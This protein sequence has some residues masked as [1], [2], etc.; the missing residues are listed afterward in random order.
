MTNS[1]FQTEI[2][3]API[4]WNKLRAPWEELLAKQSSTINDLDVTAGQ[5]WAEILW[6]THLSSGAIEVLTLQQHA[7]IE[8]ILP[9]FRQSK[10]IR[11]LPFRGLA[12]ITE[13]YSGRC[14][15][16]LREQTESL[17]REL[18]EK[19]QT[20]TSAWDLL[21][22]TL[23]RDSPSEK[24]LLQAASAAGF[25][26]QHIEEQ[27]SPYIPFQ[28][29]WEQHFSSLPKK[30]R[31]TIRNGEK[32]L[33]DR[34]E[35]S[36]RECLTPDDA[37]D[38]NAAVVEIERDSWKEAAGTSIAANPVHEAFHRA[39]TVRAAE[40][41]FFSG[42]LLLLGGQPIAYV[43]GLLYNGVFL[44]LKESYRNSFRE[45]SPSHVLKNFL[46]TRL[47]ERKA[48]VYDFMGNC[49]EYKMK[50]TDKTYCRNTY[51]LFNTT[52]RGRLAAQL[53]AMGNP[54]PKS[55]SPFKAEDLS[56]NGVK[57]K[58]HGETSELNKKNELENSSKTQE[59]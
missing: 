1:V 2:L 36:Y 45:A 35:L 49:E 47:Y 3:R 39:I 25:S 11:K 48:T 54:A 17:L 27:Y 6:E 8:N 22:L 33:R 18:L 59:V 23:L 31:S 58:E 57:L 15:F 38:F 37:H 46:F 10:T 7:K 12:L 32:R 41:G 44:D 24:L 16:L 28:E 55:N 29:N 52:L 19:L 9:F 20:Q 21:T 53:S 42:H 34:G 43:M 30:F 4:A 5:D 26:L 14:G 13:L 51:L 40:R 56:P 50:W